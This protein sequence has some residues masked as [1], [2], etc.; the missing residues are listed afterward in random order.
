MILHFITLQISFDPKD[1]DL[2]NIWCLCDCFLRVRA[3]G[4]RDFLI[5]TFCFY[6]KFY[7]FSCCGIFINEFKAVFMCEDML[8]EVITKIVLPR[9]K[10]L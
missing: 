6:C 2:D 1:L 3:K 8:N 9:S 10:V 5:N 4:L 7:D